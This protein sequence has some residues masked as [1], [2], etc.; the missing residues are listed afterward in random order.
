[1]S[2]T[3]CVTSRCNYLPHNCHRGNFLCPPPKLFSAVI[4][5][6]VVL[7][8]IH[9][10]SD[11][12]IS[13]GVWYRIEFSVLVTKKKLSDRMSR[14]YT[15]GR[16]FWNYAQRIMTKWLFSCKWKQMGCILLERSQNV[17]LCHVLYKCILAHTPQD[18]SCAC[19][20]NDVNEVEEWSVVKGYNANLIL[21]TEN[22]LAV[23]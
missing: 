7:F 13:I 1:M 14:E 20:Q 3:R 17:W 22:S 4:C 9:K 16:L 21:H 6:K 11:D 23:D 10:R 12:I 18:V 2:A 8:D 15:Q 19:T 5:H